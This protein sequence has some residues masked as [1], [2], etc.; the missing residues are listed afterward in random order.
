[1]KSSHLILFLIL[2]W[3]ILLFYKR[4]EYF[5]HSSN[6]PRTGKIKLNIKSLKSLLTPSPRVEESRYTQLYNKGICT[7][8]NLPPTYAIPGTE[9]AG[10]IKFCK[11]TQGSGIPGG[12]IPARNMP[13]SACNKDDF[14]RGGTI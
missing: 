8:Y 3:I 12:L 14:T 2:F 1:M 10:N 5:S 11:C 7:A 6:M 9:Q 4:R 13:N